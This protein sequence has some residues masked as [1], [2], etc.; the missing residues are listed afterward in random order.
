VGEIPQVWVQLVADVIHGLVMASDHDRVERCILVAVKQ[1]LAGLTPQTRRNLV[2]PPPH[3]VLV[4]A[5]EA[6]EVGF[7]RIGAQR[8]P[9][10]RDR[11]VVSHKYTRFGP[12]GY[13]YCGT[14]GTRLGA[15]RSEIRSGAKGALRYD[16]VSERLDLIDRID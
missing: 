13:E 3:G 14:G 7:T 12:I 16:R 6:T 5:R 10:F 15:E 11:T 8:S 2:G 9:D 1:T 4:V